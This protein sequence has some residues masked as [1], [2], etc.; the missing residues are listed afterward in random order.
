MSKILWATWKDHKHPQAGG[1]EVVARELTQRMAAEGH[2]VTI[3][4]CGYPGSSHL[5]NSEGI[6]FVRVGS[7]RYLHPFQAMAYYFKYMRGGYDVVVEEVQG[8]A[9]YF[10]S[11]FERKPRFLLYHQLARI[12]WLYEVP[13]PFSY[14]GYWLIAPLATKLAALSK[15][16]VI[17]VS[18]STRQALSHYGFP[19]QKSHIIS[20]GLHF[21]RLKSLK[22]VGKYKRPTILSFGAMRAMKRTLDQVKAFEIAKRSMPEL[23]MKVGGSTSGAYG[24]K[25]QDYIS[26]SPYKD[27]IEVLGKVSSQTKSELMQKSHVI[28]VTS[29]E[30]G[31]GLIVSEAN[32]QGT[33][34]VVYNVS[35]L[36]DS[37]RNGET[38]IV[39]ETNPEALAAET[40]GL[41]NKP[42][43]YERLRRNGWKWSK[44]LIFDASYRDFKQVIGLKI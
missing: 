40:V 23:Q 14:V 3:L 18:E 31:W 8:C 12:N 15:A 10:I 19:V 42:E 41:L 32:G 39:T 43:K 25:V 34:A 24:K 17:T 35:G 7:S 38:G 1:A 16:P 26:H 21:N 28:L 13:R 2:E 33:P 4:T 30:E 44:D 5:E 29:V 9:P 22:G 37:V 11:Y 6:Q 36:R 20:E 27:D